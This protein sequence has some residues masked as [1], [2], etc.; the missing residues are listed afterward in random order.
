[1]CDLY[2]WGVMK[3]DFESYRKGDILFL[4]DDEATIESRRGHHS[5]SNY[6]GHSAISRYFKVPENLFEHYESDITVPDVIA[7]EINAGHLVKLTKAAIKNGDGIPREAKSWKFIYDGAPGFKLRGLS[8]EEAPAN[9]PI[10]H[11]HWKRFFKELAK[12]TRAL[13]LEQPEVAHT[14]TKAAKVV[15]AAIRRGVS[16][17]TGLPILGPISGA[18]NSFVCWD[19]HEDCIDAFMALHS[20]LR[21]Y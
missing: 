14:F 8:Y 19:K 1:M 5:L 2:S 20:M 6:I 4:T 11:P 15:R 18:V 17:H 12:A 16:E 9:L 10:D 21:I 7:K 13:C 3:E